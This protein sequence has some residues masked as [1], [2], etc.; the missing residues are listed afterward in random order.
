MLGGHLHLRR[1]SLG[2]V[3]TLGGRP[4][5]LKSLPVNPI[6]KKQK[7][8]FFKIIVLL[9]LGLL[10]TNKRLNLHWSSVVQENIVDRNL[11]E[12]NNFLNCFSCEKRLDMISLLDGSFACSLK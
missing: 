11:Y 1:R 7:L 10:C 2:S 12:V 5:F 4:G 9:S 6:A 8:T 3:N